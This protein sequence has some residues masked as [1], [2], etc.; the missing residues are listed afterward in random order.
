MRDER[1]FPDAETFD[2][3]RFLSKLTM[4]ENEHVHPLNRFR[5]DDPSSL[6]FGFGRRC[7]I[8]FLLVYRSVSIFNTLLTEYA[9]VD[10]SLMPVH[11]L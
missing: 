10:I 8:S 6:A 3:D 11:G 2:P 7:V 1:F 9:L 4:S 5:P